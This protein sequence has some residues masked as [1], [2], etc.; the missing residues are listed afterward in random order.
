MAESASARWTRAALCL[1]F[2]A[3]GVASALGVPLETPDEV[4]SSLR[5]SFARREPPDEANV[6]VA[7]H[8]AGDTCGDTPSAVQFRWGRL[9]VAVTDRRYV[10]AAQLKRLDQLV[11]RRRVAPGTNLFDRMI[12]CDD[13]ARTA[14]QPLSPRSRGSF[15]AVRAFVVEVGQDTWGEPAVL[16]FARSGDLWLEAEEP[17]RFMTEKERRVRMEQACGYPADTPLSPD[18]RQVACYHTRF[19]S[20]SL[21]VKATLQAEDMIRL[22]QL[23]PTQTPAV[24]T[25]APPSQPEARGRSVW[26]VRVLSAAPIDTYRQLH[27]R[28]KNRI[29]EVKSSV[30]YAGPTGTVERPQVSLLSDGGQEIG[31]FRTAACRGADGRCIESMKWLNGPGQAGSTRMLSQGEA[32]ADGA[33]ELWFEAPKGVERLSLQFGDASAIR[34]R[35]EP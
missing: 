7:Q 13:A 29:I 1:G 22:A 17:P 35:L 26:Q 10:N 31:A 16:V 4:R 3:A 23:A 11:A 34:L 19:W 14:M 24:A 15:G 21:L 18:D 9:T 20:R 2:V 32:L 27:D 12:W 30:T 25:S 33:L 5:V 28:R 8:E 6:S